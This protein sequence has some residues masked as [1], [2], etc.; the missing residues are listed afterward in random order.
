MTSS[1]HR[2]RPQGAGVGDALRRWLAIPEGLGPRAA[3]L[4]AMIFSLSASLA[5]LKAAQSGLFLEVFSRDMIP[6]A[7]A[8]SALTLA[9]VSSLLVSLTPRLGPARLASTSLAVSVVVTLGLWGLAQFVDG[10]V[11]RFVAYVVIEAMS[12]VLIIQVWSAAIN[13]TDARTARKLLP[14]AG[15]GG[16]VAWIIAGLATG[17]L[18]HSLGTKALLLIAPGLLL[19]GLWV[20]RLCIRLDMGATRIRTRSRD[21]L[22]AAW[23]DGFRFV[24]SEPLMRLAAVLALLTLLG[25]EFMDVLLMSTAREALVDAERISAFF[26]K[27]YAA[28][29]AVGLVLLSGLTGRLLEALGATRSLLVPPLTVLVGSLVVLALPSLATV[30]ALRGAA[31]VLKQ[32]LWSSSVE[33]LQ[34]PLSNLRRSQAKAAIRGVLAPM[35][36]GVSA[37]LLGLLS[38][39][40]TTRV[41]AVCV[42]CTTAAA[43]TL[44]LVRARRVYRGALHRAIDERRILLGPGRSPSSANLDA[45]AC[46][47]L[48]E[49]LE[50]EEVER[51][52]LAAEVLSMSGAKLAAVSLRLGLE[53]P[54]A[55][56]RLCAVR[57]LARLSVEGSAPTLGQLL[58]ADESAEVRAACAQALR[59]V[60]HRPEVLEVFRTGESDRD[61]LVATACKVGRLERELEGEALGT[62]LGELLLDQPGLPVVLDTLNEVTALGR[63]VHTRLRELLRIGS[64]FAKLQAS[65][66]VVRLRLLDLL[67]DVVRLLK[68]PRVAVPAARHLV[69]LDADLMDQPAVGERT[70][71]TSLSHLATRFAQSAE[72]P[73]VEAMVLRLLDH[74]DVE[75]REHATHALAEAVRLGRRPALGRGAVEPLIM[76]ECTSAYA[77]SSVLAGV[78]H[79]DG[80]PDWKVEP[81]FGF[82]AREIE[83]RVETVRGTILDLLLLLGR[84]RLVSAIEVGRRQR[85]AA[86]DAQL[87]E[88]LD[89]GLPRDL[90]RI[91]VPLFERLSLRERF[92]MAQS[93]GLSQP[94]AMEDPVRAI[95]ELDDA[96][97]EG[98]AMLSFGERFRRTLPDA[99]ESLQQMVPLYERMRF[100]RSVPLFG[101]LSGE[102][103]LQLA[104]KVEQV[105]QKQGDL[106]FAKDDPG[107]GLYV[108]VS[109]RVAVN[110]GDRQVATMGPAEFFG[111]LA[112]LDHAPRSADVTCLA[113]CELLRLRGADLEELLAER[114]QAMRE[115]LRVLAQRLRASS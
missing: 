73:V 4:V 87:A 41:L 9:I 62:A 94:H 96:L 50:H 82:L 10:P 14:V 18:S 1:H 24:R 101:E 111:E 105:S 107:D 53:H 106:V 85:S 54:A 100:L 90:A 6:W 61:L 80:V 57:G 19:G 11:L 66:T 15:I 31:R 79:H 52:A 34:T 71:G 55:E 32:S 23:R 81:E 56:V 64:P 36:Y 29:S 44:I 51:A 115:I 112:L 67:P 33:Q 113:D 3:R 25:E 47:A 97:L 35:G 28:T 99:A 77:L 20:L 27:Y 7:F 72:P 104:E 83:R 22:I 59:T 89:M 103:V 84:D 8:L 98:C 69:H 74:P 95:G 75:I 60:R 49:E 21:G 39:Y 5:F 26:G 78:A 91:V 114:P 2:G 76:R 109:G 58:V 40:L 13:V 17:P 45:D 108:V 12:G 102:D 70:L 110:D 16:S 88:L 93:L 92:E 43:S 30:V 48:G 37:V 38:E 65:R 86:R 68:N 46:R 42:L 63:G